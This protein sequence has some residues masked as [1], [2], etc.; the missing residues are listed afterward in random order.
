MAIAPCRACGKVFSS[1]SAFDMHRTGSY[2]RA[3]YDN[4]K[5][6]TRYIKGDRRCCT[7]Q[8]IT[9]KGMIKNKRG[10]WTTGVFDASAFAKPDAAES[11]EG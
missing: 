6:V 8:E 11:E 3:V 7:E 10:Y 1:T 2:G 4:D 5:K 9:D